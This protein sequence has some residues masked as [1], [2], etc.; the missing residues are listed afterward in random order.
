MLSS[1][2]LN[3]ILII[4]KISSIILILTMR[5]ERTPLSKHCRECH[6]YQVLVGE[7]VRTEY[8]DTEN[9]RGLYIT[10]SRQHSN[11]YL[12]LSPA[13][14]G[15]C[16]AS[17]AVILWEGFSSR[18]LYSKS[19]AESGKLSHD[20][21]TSRALLHTLTDWSTDGVELEAAVDFRLGLAGMCERLSGFFRL[22]GDLSS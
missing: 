4:I 3:T 15:C 5:K 8:R 12:A 6:W 20:L 18:H 14:K 9:R 7:S 10:G 17:C 2:I 19:Y 13:R 21:A 11:C 16:R 22:C 1:I